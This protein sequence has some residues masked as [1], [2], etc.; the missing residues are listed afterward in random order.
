[1]P[2]SGELIKSI[3]P[4]LGMNELKVAKERLAILD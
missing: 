2:I 1:M 3:F 4:Y